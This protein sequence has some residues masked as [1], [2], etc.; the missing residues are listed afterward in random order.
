MESVCF[1]WRANWGE[2]T[3]DLNILSFTRLYLDVY[4]IQ[5]Q[6]EDLNIKILAQDKQEKALIKFRIYSN[7]YFDITFKDMVA[8]VKRFL[9]LPYF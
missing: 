9:Q 8:L 4:E 5:W 3:N 6:S 1:V 2:K 7:V